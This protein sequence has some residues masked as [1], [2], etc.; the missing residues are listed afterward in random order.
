MV[1][2]M[3][4]TLDHRFLW[5][6]LLLFDPGWKRASQPPRY[7]DCGLVGDPMRE[8]STGESH[9]RLAGRQTTKNDGLSHR[10]LSE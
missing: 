9:S 1:L 6:V 5:S 4:S 8:V 3:G 7:E 10:T 2:T